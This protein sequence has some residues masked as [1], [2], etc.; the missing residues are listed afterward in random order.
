M[1]TYFLLIPLIELST[2]R[3]YK[4]II[5]LEQFRHGP[6]KDDT[7]N[8]KEY[9]HMFRANTAN[10]VELIN[11]PADGL[12]E[13]NKLIA[14]YRLFEFDQEDWNPLGESSERLSKTISN[15]EDECQEMI[16]ELNEIIKE[17]KN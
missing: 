4:I 2:K 1:K 9:T 8:V 14:N 15:K 10:Q 13:P 3:S 17:G 11:I 7:G 5:E 12:P 6:I 16:D